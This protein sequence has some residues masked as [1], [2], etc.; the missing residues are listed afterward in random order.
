M[1]DYSLKIHTIDDV[2]LVSFPYYGIYASDLK[3]D[4]GE[5]VY[6]HRIRRKGGKVVLD[7]SRKPIKDAIYHPMAAFADSFE[8]WIRDVVRSGRANTMG[9]DSPDIY[10]YVTP[11]N[12]GSGS[13]LLAF[14]CM[15]YHGLIID[16]LAL[17]KDASGNMFLTMPHHTI[18]GPDGTRHPVDIVEIS[19]PHEYDR[20]M[21]MVLEKYQIA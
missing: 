1:S 21:E 9:L 10:V 14:V 6:P 19:D 3:I 2:S 8:E 4:H 16:D 17:K 7:A 11:R 13:D 15:N 12:F 5:V 18:T 20:I